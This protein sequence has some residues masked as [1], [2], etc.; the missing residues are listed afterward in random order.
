MAITRYYFR[1]PVPGKKKKTKIVPK[2]ISKIH[3]NIKLRFLLKVTN[4]FTQ[5][6]AC[7]RYFYQFFIF[8][9]K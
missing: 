1:F 3:G 9:T 8:F 7:V 4:S 6:K 2:I 5:F